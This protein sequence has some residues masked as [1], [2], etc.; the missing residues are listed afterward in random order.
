[1]VSRGLRWGQDGRAYAWP[2]HDGYYVKEKTEEQLVHDAFHDALTGLP[3]RALFMD[4]LQHII[5]V[6]HRRASPLY[7]VLFLDMDR[8]K[9]INDS[10]GH[11]VG[12]QLLIA[13]GRR[14]AECI[15]PG[16]S[17]ARLR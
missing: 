15:R 12:D 4:R 10:L 11:G 1:M 13:V 5:T 6:S 17:V 14:L 16:D 2:D 3:N 8:F 7:A 9:T